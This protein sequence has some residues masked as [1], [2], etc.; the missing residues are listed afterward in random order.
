LDL[1]PSDQAA[2]V[3]RLLGEEGDASVSERAS[4]DQQRV[5]A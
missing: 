3:D 1:Y 2:E 5:R 4:R